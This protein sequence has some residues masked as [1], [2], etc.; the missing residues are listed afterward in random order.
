MKLLEEFKLFE[1]MWDDLKSE[2]VGAM[3][4]DVFVDPEPNKSL[5]DCPKITTGRTKIAND[6]YANCLEL[7][8]ATLPDSVKLI[9]DRAFY[10]SGIETL[11]MGKNLVYVGEDAFN[12]CTNLKTMII[13][14]LENY[15]NICFE[16]FTGPIFYA[17]ELII[18]GK[19]FDGNLT[20]SGRRVRRGAFTG[21]KLLTKLDIG[22]R[23]EIENH[24]FSDCYNLSEV[25]IDEGVTTI[26]D[27]AFY[28]NKSLTRIFIP[29]SV[30]SFG[31]KIFDFPYADPII[32]IVCNPGSY[33]EE[34]AKENGYTVELTS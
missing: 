34:F 26:G 31:R 3:T 19:P 15:C 20:V 5:A 25:T 22:S 2:E 13:P 23:V 4:E 17:K 10:F 28:N 12:G 32:T 24:A 16:D 9:G 11:K 7:K 33:A 30:V 18:E 6:A 8:R 29:D 21:C 1:E 14:N 27:S